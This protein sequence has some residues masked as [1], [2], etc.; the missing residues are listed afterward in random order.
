MWLAEKAASGGGAA[1]TAEIGVVTIS[2]N[3]PSVM[4]GGEKRNVELLVFPGLSW[5]PAA[6][7]QVL[8][9]RAGD[10]Y[11]VCGAP[12]VED[13]NGLAA[14][15]FRLKSR[16]ASVTVRNGGGIELRGS[17]NV[18]GSLS[19]NGTNIFDLFMQRGGDS[20]GA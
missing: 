11:F 18:A 19:I 16:G 14:G 4:L 12:G 17:V 15:E 7:E 9:L 20:D 3:K 8:V 2:G 13:G 10:E 6:G 5:K 1:E